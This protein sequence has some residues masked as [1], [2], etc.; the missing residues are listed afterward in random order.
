MLTDPPVLVRVD[1]AR[2][3]LAKTPVSGFSR[4]ERP[5]G[6]ACL[7][8]DELWTLADSRTLAR[9][10]T[11]GAVLG[12]YKLPQPRLNVF[13]VGEVLLLQQPPLSPN[14][15]LLA[16]ARTGDLT[17]SQPWP[18]PMAPPQVTKKADLASGLV[19]CGVEHDNRLPCWIASQSR[20]TISDG[21]SAHTSIVQPAFVD[22]SAVDR[23]TPLQ[24]VAATSS[25]GL[26]IL[27]SAVA[28]ESGRRV[29]GRLT[30]SNLR[31]ESLASIDLQPRARLIVDATDS[32]AI[33]LTTAGT[34][35]EVRAR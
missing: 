23:R 34:L 4:A 18:G 21:T 16:A 11:S 35:V 3:S 14:I 26:W 6:L 9:M 2:F 1:I 27:T 12:R 5:F 22:D 25:T 10:S 33:V 32:S 31:G 20:I 13:G 19:S 28:R 29:G 15:P 30:R 7:A 8:S 24:D 17:R